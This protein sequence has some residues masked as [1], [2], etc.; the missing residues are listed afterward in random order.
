[1][2]EGSVTSSIKY[3]KRKEGRAKNK[4][5]IAGKTVHTVSISW[6]S[7]ILLQMY[8]FNMRDKKP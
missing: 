1:V 5:I 3:S 7:K 8:L 4:R 6:A 2:K